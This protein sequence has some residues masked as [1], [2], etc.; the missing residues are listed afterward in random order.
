MKLN[1]SFIRRSLTHETKELMCDWNL[2]SQRS[3][4]LLIAKDTSFIPFIILVL[5]LFKSRELF[6]LWIQGGKYSK[7]EIDFVQEGRSWWC[8]HLW[9]SLC[10]QARIRNTLC[11]LWFQCLSPQHTHSYLFVSMY[12]KRHFLY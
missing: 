2:Q 11:C 8:S 10:Q 4:W 5:R 6:S 3:Q 12:W 9:W 7:R 1:C